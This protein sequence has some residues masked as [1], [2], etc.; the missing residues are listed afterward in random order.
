MTTVLEDWERKHYSEGGDL[1]FLFYVVFGSDAN[2]LR[3]SRSKHRCDSVPDGVAISSYGPNTHPEVL[4]EFRQGYLWN[5]LRKEESSLANEV[6]AQTKCV[7][8]QGTVAD[9][10]SLNYFRNTI[11]LLTGLLDAGG[12]A[13]YDPQSFKWWS[14][15]KWRATVFEP[16]AALP[17]EHVVILVSDE[18][19][20]A[21][22]V[23]TRGMRKFGRPD[24]STHGVLPDYFDSVVD[25]LNRF[26]EFQAFGGVIPEGQEIRM[27]SLPSVLSRRY[28]SKVDVVFP[29]W[30]LR[31]R[32]T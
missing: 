5:E 2:E 32:S 29:G 10:T 27:Q 13:I 20:Q 22:W 30:N 9:D 4:N 7:I 28:V 3:L 12:V 23:H 25:L 11:G 26:I 14:S 21:K 8:V 15:E 18:G 1:P 16:A 19:H 24:L 6:E 31:W 17:R